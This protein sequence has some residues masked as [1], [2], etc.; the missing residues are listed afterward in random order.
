MRKRQ[1][2]PGHDAHSELGAKLTLGAP[3]CHAAPLD[4]PRRCV[5]RLLRSRVA[6]PSA[7][8]PSSSAIAVLLPRSPG[9]SRPRC[10]RAVAHAAP[11]GRHV[12]SA[13]SHPRVPRRGHTDPAWRA[14]R[15]T[16]CCTARSRKAGLQRASPTACSCSSEDPACAR[17]R[18][19]RHPRAGAPSCAS[20]ST[21]ATP[22]KL[23]PPA[24]FQ[25]GD[26]ASPSY[27]S[28]GSTPLCA[29][30]SPPGWSRC[31][32]SRTRP[33]S[34]K[35]PAAGPTPIR[36]AGRPIRW[37]FQQFA[38]AAGSPLRRRFPRSAQLGGVLATGALV[39]GL[40]RAQPGALPRAPMGGE[41]QALERLLAAALPAALTASTPALRP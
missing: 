3:L 15:T 7:L 39:P 30:P 33:P 34:P 14:S 26:P 5:T 12:H 10:C 36:A 6:M 18:L 16:P 25:A 4:A 9:C 1:S 19:S 41:R 35:H 20:P 38:T 32:S 28:P 27:V 2:D 23:A 22:S 29:A 31:W 21:G 40:E 13:P 8:T 24:S 37:R 11:T 17:S